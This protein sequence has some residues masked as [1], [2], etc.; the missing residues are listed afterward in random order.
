M[1]GKAIEQQNIQLETGTTVVKLNP[2]G[3]KPGVYLLQLVNAS[4]I[5]KQLKLV[6][7]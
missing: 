3:L 2:I 1:Q 7:N 4:T 6:V 5:E